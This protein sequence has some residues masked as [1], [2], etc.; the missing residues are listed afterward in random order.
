MAR[1]LNGLQWAHLA[2]SGPP[3]ASTRTKVSTSAMRAGKRFEKRL[4]TLVAETL[5]PEG[6]KVYWGQWIAFRDSAGFGM[7][8]PDIILRRGLDLILI[9][10]KLTQTFSAWPQME[11]LY[12]PLLHSVFPGATV[13]GRV[14]AVNRIKTLDSNAPLTTLEE[15]SKLNIPQRRILHLPLL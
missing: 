3:F 4:A 5:E 12:V 9:E 10:A 11:Q 7:A 6:W 8:Q 14:Q 1:R 2:D 13:G 15:L